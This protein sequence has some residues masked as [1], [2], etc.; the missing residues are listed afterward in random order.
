MKKKNIS[1][2]K[3]EDDKT[4][5]EVDVDAQKDNVLRTHHNRKTIISK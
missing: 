1:S 4:E 2:D 3:I 5:D